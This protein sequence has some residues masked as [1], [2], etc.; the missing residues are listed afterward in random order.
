MADSVEAD[1]ES[2]GAGFRR[3]AGDIDPIRRPNSHSEVLVVQS[4]QNWHRQGATP[5]AVFIGSP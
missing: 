5:A 4:A 1:I 3:A 2:Y